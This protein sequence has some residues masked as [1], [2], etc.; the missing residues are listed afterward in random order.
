MLAPALLAY[1]GGKMSFTGAGAKPGLFSRMANSALV[2]L[3]A[4]VPMTAAMLI[5]YRF[6]PRS[7][8]Y[9]LPPRQITMKMAA[10]AGAKDKLDQPQE[11]TA[12]TLAGHFSYGVGAGAVYPL[13]AGWLPW[14]GWLRGVV[15]GLALWLI[16]YMGWVPAANLLPKPSDTPARRNALMIAAHVVYGAA[17]GWASRNL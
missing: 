11:R 4:T 9:P 6:L 16:S 14:P 15:Y 2:G 13:A 5:L 17:L 7:E 10:K 1:Q 8:K 3:I 12:A